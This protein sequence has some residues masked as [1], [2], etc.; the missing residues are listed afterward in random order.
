LDTV[1]N[2]T[3]RY[4]LLLA[5]TTA[6]YAQ[7]NHN[8][9]VPTITDVRCALEECGALGSGLETGAEE[10]W[11]ERLRRPIEG[12]MEVEAG[13]AARARA[14][15]RRRAERDVADVKELRVWFEGREMAEINRI[16]GMSGDATTG[17]VGVGG[18][19]VKVEDFLTTVKKK[20]GRPGD[21]EGEE[22]LVGT[23][24]GRQGDGGT[25][26]GAERGMDIEGGP[27]LW[28]WEERAREKARANATLAHDS[29]VDAGSTTTE[30]GDKRPLLFA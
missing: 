6:T 10:A 12:M 2:L 29:G 5:Q 11:E 15:E 4:L 8:D 13:G 3:E 18:G 26:N 16:A 23:V 7:N 30:E 22:R 21:V 24:L 28:V 9:V 19:R 25:P 20:Q 17:G 27:K 1:V 14:E